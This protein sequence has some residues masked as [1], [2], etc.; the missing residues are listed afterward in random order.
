MKKRIIAEANEFRDSNIYNGISLARCIEPGML[1]STGLYI[2]SPK[3]ILDDILK[4]I[5]PVALFVFYARYREIGMMYKPAEEPPKLTPRECDV[6]H[7]IALGWTKQEVAARLMVSTSCV[8][9]YCENISCKLGTNN[10]ASA[11]ARAMSYGM[12][13]I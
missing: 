9:R 10:M 3:I 2:P 13:N 8:K 12:I 6:L 4:R 7:W 5:L 1:V 11:V